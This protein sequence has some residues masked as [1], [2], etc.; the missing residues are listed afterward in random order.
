MK[1]WGYVM[2][3]F[4]LAVFLSPK[5]VFATSGTILSGHS[6]A[7]S[8]QV[9]Y[10][11]F[12]NTI[13]SDSV[14]TGYAWS[15]N[16]GWIKMNPTNGGVTND[17]AGNISGYAWGESLG[18]INFAGVTIGE[19][20][21]FFGT[22]SGDL[23]G[24]L[25][26]GCTQCD[27][28][29][30]WRATSA[31]SGTGGT[32]G[33]GIPTPP[34]PS[35]PETPPDVPPEVPQDTLPT[36]AV[37]I[38][39][40]AIY[41]NNR[42][43]T[44]QFVT[45][46]VDSYALSFNTNFSN[47][48]FLSIVFSVQTTL[49]LGD[50]AKHVYVRFQNK[51]GIHDATDSIILDTTAPSAPSITS[52]DNGVEH[53]IRVRPPKISGKTEPFAKVILTKT[54]EGSQAMNVLSLA[55]VTTYYVDADSQGNWTFTFGGMLSQGSYAMSAQAQDQ[56]GNI[57]ISSSV[58][59]LVI[60][61]DSIPPP[62]DETIPPA[63]PP[64]D[65]TGGETDAG[66]DAQG[67]NS[68]GGGGGSVFEHAAELFF[69][70]SSIK[71]IMDIT[72]SLTETTQENVRTVVS[73]TKAVAEQIRQQIGKI[74]DLIPVSVRDVTQQVVQTIQHVADNP[75]VEKVN[76]QIVA[77]TAV[78]VGASNV[79]VGFNLPQMLLFF[80][81]L[82]TQPL[83]LLRRRKHKKWGTVYNAYTKQPIDLAMIRII[84]D[85]TNTIVTSQVTDIHGRYYILLNP[86]TYRIEVHHD[87][88]DVGSSLL[89]HVD[90]DVVF[91][92]IYHVGTTITVTDKKVELNLNIPLDP[93]DDNVSTKIIIREYT[94]NA[95]QY[96]V[97][98]VGLGA[99]LLSL[100][101]SPNIYILALLAMHIIFLIMF[102]VFQKRRR[103]KQV[104][105]IRDEKKKHRLGRVAVRIFDATYNKLVETSVT[106]RKGRYGALV[107]PSMYYVTY[108][109]P[110]YTKKKSPLLN[111][112]S[113]KTE[114]IGG[115]I[116]RDE[117]L[118]SLPSSTATKKQPTSKD[119]NKKNTANNKE[120]LTRTTID[121]GDISPDEEEAL[122]DIAQY[123]KGKDS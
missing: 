72:T 28:Q 18:W 24:T 94:K 9:G 32:S 13:V 38:N 92:N 77:P 1:R 96:A 67:G 66:N 93:T 59:H 108:D 19:T 44:L 46:Y 78:V 3:I 2:F 27:V 36:G 64:V 29:T 21:I 15:Q 110:G 103:T 47:A 62:P 6:Y 112:T 35:P 122:G 123:G 104:G 53:G 43:V 79:A 70:T 101:I 107:G 10:I 98:M 86:G 54:T 40:D 31:T 111:F 5:S 37:V 85:K 52:V 117:R 100:Y 89:Q 41:T 50:G 22:A 4:V 7:W 12:S 63:Q 74:T 87:G 14:L 69:S 8:N 114:G 82:F 39:A 61:A 55:G 23:V 56:A 65:G 80:R 75:D 58:T 115:V 51:Y 25:T 113:K 81:Y 119:K 11:N 121:D 48:V 91:D 120:D 57:S 106:D 16:S 95:I 97:S 88:F 109:K 116:A 49:P 42:T 83:L 84:R 45:D 99:T 60:P 102:T 68:T 73:S 105:I 26:F 118:S 33:S 17:G 30:D 71:T 34:P 76:Q 90:H 20:G